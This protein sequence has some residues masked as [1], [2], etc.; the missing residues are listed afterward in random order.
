MSTA[1][2]VQSADSERARS[3][4]SH[5][6]IRHVYRQWNL[7]AAPCRILSLWLRPRWWGKMTTMWSRTGPRASE[8]RRLLRPV[9][10]SLETAPLT[11]PR[12]PHTNVGGTIPTVL[13]MRVPNVCT[14]TVPLLPLVLS[15][16]LAVGTR[17]L[18]CIYFTRY[19]GLIS[20]SFSLNKLSHVEY[21]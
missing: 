21:M 18:S 1:Y 13:Y 12:S 8:A 16:P 4:A 10:V 6:G 5:R 11:W 17:Q 19:L 15:A 20:L 9:D 7:E 3:P 14:V 2:S